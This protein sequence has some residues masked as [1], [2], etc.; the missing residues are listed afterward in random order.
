MAKLKNLRSVSDPSGQIRSGLSPRF[1]RHD[2]FMAGLY[3]RSG[4][5]AEVVR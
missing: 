2:R 4:Q 1:P 5:A 3:S